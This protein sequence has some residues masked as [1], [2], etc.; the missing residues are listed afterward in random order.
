MNAE[1]AEQHFAN[2][3]KEDV[4]QRVFPFNELMLNERL[5]IIKALTQFA[6][7]KIVS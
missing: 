5:L 6:E 3:L 1:Q 4:E 2:R 7:Q